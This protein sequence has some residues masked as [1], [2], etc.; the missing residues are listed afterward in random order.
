MTLSLS[1]KM[2]HLG[3]TSMARYVYP[4][5]FHP[6]EKDG[7]YFISF[8]DLPGCFTE[9]NDMADAMYM[10]N[11]VLEMWLAYTEDRHEPIPA[12]TASPQVE[13]PEFVNLVLADT[14]AWR[15]KYDS[16]AVKK[17]L[18]IPNWLNTRAE[19]AGVNFSQILQDALKERL[20]LS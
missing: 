15:K 20:D 10:A 4:A 11:D 5:I 19:E 2:I 1:G 14:D 17:T 6:D 9:G 18:S 3:G 13:A 16:R 7:G 8:P 12:P